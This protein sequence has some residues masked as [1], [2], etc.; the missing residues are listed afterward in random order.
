MQ[1]LFSI[2]TPVY[3]PPLDVLA[4][5]IRSVRNQSF[6]DWELILVDDCSPDPAVR[7]LLRKQ[8]AADSRIKV[9]ER[10]TNGHIV[11]ASND[12]FAAAHG[13]FI[14]LLDHDDVIVDNALLKMSEAIKNNPDVG[15]LYSDEEIIDENDNLLQPFRKATWS[16]ERLRGQ[17]YTNH[18]SVL[19]TDLVRQVG[20]FRPGFDGSQDHDLVLRVT[21][22]AD[23]VVHIPE[24]L[25]RWRAVAGSAAEST[26]AKPYAWHAGLRAVN[27]HL[28]RTGVAGHAELGPYAGTYRVV[29]DPL[30]P[31][32][33]VSV[34]IPT[35]GESGEVFGQERVFILEAI[36]S[37][38]EKGGHANLEFVVVYDT[39][40]PPAVLGALRELLGDKLILVPYD[41]PFN[42]SEKCNLGVIYSHGSV[43]LLANDDIE[44]ISDNLIGKLVAPLF[45]P[46]V[47]QT[48]AMLLFEDGTIQHAG[49]QVV[50]TLLTHA[51]MGHDPSEPVHLYATDVDREVFGVT[52]AL[53]AIKRITYDQIGGFTELLFNNYN[54]VDLSMK[55]GYLGLRRLYIADARA[56]HF[57]SKTRKQDNSSQWEVDFIRRRWEMPFFDP[58]LPGVRRY[59][60]QSEWALVKQYFKAGGVLEVAR[61][62]SGR[63]RKQVRRKL[64]LRE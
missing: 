26:D 15:Y 4:K 7:E 47:G 48:G 63:I 10:P 64:N 1:P 55:I 38:L 2:V 59:D 33:L 46:G 57:E 53:T 6:K 18:F 32:V 37:L 11:A 9:I 60:L 5:T 13:K 44:A 34:I 3:N 28:Q 52:A 16:P 30:P 40:T 42:Y 51:H 49:V 21:E 43:L 27:E 8:A 35:R 54:D 20:G 39:P 45:E 14:A 23:G 19:R 17:M 12:G 62:A 36:R 22:L 61:R 50:E 24:V 31:D 25:Y 58:Y 56:Y 29:R 41:K